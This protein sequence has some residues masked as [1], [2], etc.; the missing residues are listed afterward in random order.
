MAARL[1]IGNMRANNSISKI[2]TASENNNIITFSQITNQ[3]YKHKI[4]NKG[5]NFFVGTTD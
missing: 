3:V 5:W 4:R 1:Y 2:I